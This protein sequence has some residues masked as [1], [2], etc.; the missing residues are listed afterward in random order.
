MSFR[1]HAMQTVADDLRCCTGPSAR[2]SSCEETGAPGFTRDLPPVKGYNGM[3]LLLRSLQTTAPVPVVPINRVSVGATLRSNSFGGLGLLSELADPS[4]VNLQMT[5]IVNALRGAYAAGLDQINAAHGTGLV[6]FFTGTSAQAASVLA[7][8]GKIPALID[9]LDTQFRQQVLDGQ[10]PDGTPYT[11]ENWISYA[12]DIGDD[13]KSQ[14]SYSWDASGLTV[15][16]ETAA[17]TKA[18]V[19]KAAEVGLGI[20]TA[21]L[22]IGG[23]GYLLVVSGAAGPLLH[24]LFSRG[25]KS[26]AMAGLGFDRSRHKRTKR[27]KRKLRRRT[28]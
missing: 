7:N 23:V 15:L 6:D 28:A 12:N 19:A 27:A 21:A 26:T 8:Y 13:I 5:Q 14:A 2:P 16:R 24:K 4:A 9:Q 20:G 25:G 11:V 22:V 17:A 1:Q 10:K 3:P 18:Q